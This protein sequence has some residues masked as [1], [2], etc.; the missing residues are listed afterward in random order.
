MD[1]KMKKVKVGMIVEGKAIVVTDESVYL[2]L[3][4]F[5]EGVIHKKEQKK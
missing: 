5:A 2:D 1:F 3:E 4:T